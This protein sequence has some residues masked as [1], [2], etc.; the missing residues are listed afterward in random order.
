MTNGKKTKVRTLRHSMAAA[1][2]VRV[3]RNTAK[4]KL[5]SA[6]QVREKL[7]N[8]GLSVSAFARDNGVNYQTVIK[9]LAGRNTG[10][11]GEAHRVAVLLKMKVGTATLA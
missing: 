1:A 4:T 10:R 11:Y 2:A 9:V 3:I 8:E 5:L 6:E 7:K